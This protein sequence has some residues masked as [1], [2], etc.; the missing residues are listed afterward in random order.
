MARELEGVGGGA[1]EHRRHRIHP[2]GFH[3]R[4]VRGIHRTQRLLR[5]HVAGKQSVG[6]CPHPLQHVR[7]A[8]QRVEHEGG[9]ARHGIQRRDEGAHRR[10]LQ[11]RLGKEFWVGVVQVQ[12]VV[13]QVGLRA[14][15]LPHRAG[16]ALD[17]LV[18]ELVHAR[19]RAAEAR[20]PAHVGTRDQ[21]CREQPVDVADEVVV[22][23]AGRDAGH[24]GAHLVGDDPLQRRQRG[25]RLALRPRRDLAA[26]D[27]D[28]AVDVLHR[29]LARI[30]PLQRAP[31]RRMLR[32]VGA[33]RRPR[34]A[35]PGVE[36][37]PEL[38]RAN[39]LRAL[40]REEAV[41]LHPGQHG[42]A[43]VEQA[44][45]VDRPVLQVAV[46]HEGA[47]VSRHVEDAADDRQAP[48]HRYRRGGH[49]AAL[50]GRVPV[51]APKHG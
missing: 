7:V 42:E 11:V 26:G 29:V 47:H 4:A 33:Q 44:H 18:V 19:G 39:V 31:E 23:G 1:D 40:A 10:D 8:Q 6:L 9:R 50:C 51:F 37:A 15:A 43:P 38:E 28:E 17:H 36:A 20:R 2:H 32:S 30:A 5:R 21:R 13:D 12:E 41:G 49:L 48:R 46:G 14:V 34:R 16:M 3:G 27:V 35:E 22:V 24:Q 25:H 45:A